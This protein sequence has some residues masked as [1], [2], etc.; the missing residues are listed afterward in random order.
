[1]ESS[2]VLQNVAVNLSLGDFSLAVAVWM[3]LHRS[4]TN[5][6]ANPLLWGSFGVTGWFLKPLVFAYQA[7]SSLKYVERVVSCSGVPCV[8]T[9]LFKHGSSLLKLVEET[10]STSGYFEYWSITIW[11][12]FH[13]LAL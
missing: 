7:I 1:M 5:L 11:R 2:P 13:Q 8:A 6:S 12:F 4:F 3:S 9:V 10:I